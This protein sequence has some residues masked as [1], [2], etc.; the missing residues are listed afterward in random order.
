M[1]QT[2]GIFWVETLGAYLL[3]A[4]Y[5]RTPEAFY[6]MV[7]AVFHSGLVMIPFAFYEL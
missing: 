4:C 7:A 5:I 6:A 1:I 3:G 2:I